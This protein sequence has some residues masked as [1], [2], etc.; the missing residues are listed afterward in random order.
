MQNKKNVFFNVADGKLE[1]GWCVQKSPNPRFRPSVR[2]SIHPPPGLQRY[3]ATMGG[4][5]PTDSASTTSSFTLTPPATSSSSSS[6]LYHLLG[7]HHHSLSLSQGGGAVGLPVG[8]GLQPEAVLLRLLLLLQELLP[9]L[10]RLAVRLVQLLLQCLLAVL[11]SLGGWGG[12]EREKEVRVSAASGSAGV[13][14]PELGP[15]S[16]F[17]ETA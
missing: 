11:L 8:Y 13:I 14:L 5:S 9:V 6:L 10:L 2:P 4:A 7:Q 16:K 15:G 12:R 1:T 17:S 3:E